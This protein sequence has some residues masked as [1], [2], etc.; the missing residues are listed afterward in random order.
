MNKAVATQANDA[1]HGSLRMILRWKTLTS[2]G[3]WLCTLSCA[4]AFGIEPPE[5]GVGSE[6]ERI[7]RAAVRDVAAATLDQLAGDHGKPG[8]VGVPD[9]RSRGIASDAAF[10]CDGGDYLA[11]AGGEQRYGQTQQA[12]EATLASC[13][14][15]LFSEL[16]K[17]V[18]AAKDL[19]IPTDENTSLACALNGTS[20][21]AKCDVLEHLGLAFH[22]AQDFYAHTNWVDRPAAGPISARN[23]PGLA[24]T[25]RTWWLDPR[26]K[27]DFPAGLISGC[28]TGC[29]YGDW[30]PVFGLERISQ[31]DLAKDLGPI[32]NGV[33]GLGM[34]QR[35]AINDNF[36]RAVATAID[37]TSDKW[38][39]FKERVRA[40]YPGIAGETILCAVT[41]DKFDRSVCNRGASR[42]SVCGARRTVYIDGGKTT[43]TSLAQPGPDEV[44]E[45]ERLLEP[46][47][48]YCVLEEAALTRDAVINGGAAEQGRAQAKASGVQALA[49]WNACP[50]DG[51]AYLSLEKD[52]HEKSLRE[53]VTEA[54]GAGA[55]Y[56]T[57]LALVY[58]DCIVGARMHQLEK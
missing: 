48:R 53:L 14:A 41:S 10:H 52:T 43:L 4:L 5:K 51:R 32:G 1:L 39:Y 15:L 12:A 9:L 44:A 37:D 28:R 26:S 2:F 38:E 29:G 25:R 35:G 57:L 36:R 49:L 45:A 18:A 22:A 13:R 8:A 11:S 17:A 16:E 24:Q 54:P 30:S 21:A 3:L 42:E 46:L 58:A 55:K 33:G 6:H 20:G 19:S 31:A 27:A 40:S 7:T 47:R 50:V 56:R 23:P 34:T